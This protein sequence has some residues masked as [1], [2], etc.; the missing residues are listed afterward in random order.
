MSKENTNVTMEELEMDVTEVEAKEVATVEEKQPGKIKT[1]W[2]K[3][4]GKVITG[5]LIGV[6]YLLGVKRGKK[7]TSSDDC[8]EVVLE[9]DD[10]TV[11]DI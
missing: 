8:D 1:F 11:V 2:S 4:K 3:H 6:G 10:V 5:A 9:E 7:M